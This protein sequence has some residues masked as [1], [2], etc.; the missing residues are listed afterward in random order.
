MTGIRFYKAATN[1]GTHVGSLWSA[2]RPC[3]PRRPSPTKAPPAGSRSASQ[4]GRDQRQHHLRGG[5][6][7]AERALLRH[8][9]SGLTS[10][11]SNPPLTALSNASQRQRRVRVR[12]APAPSRRAPTK[13]ATTTSTS[14]SLPTPVPGP[15]TN[16]TRDRRARSGDGLLE[17]AE[18]RRFGRRIQ[19]HPLHRQR[20]A[21][22]AHASRSR[23]RRQSDVHRAAQRH[24][25]HVPGAG[26]RT[27]AGRARCRRPRT[28]SRRRH[29]PSPSA[30]LSV[31]ASAATGQARVSWSEPV[32]NGGSPITGYVVTPYLGTASSPTPV[33]APADHG[34]RR[35]GS[36][37]R[38]EPTRSR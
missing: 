29:R 10:A 2:R 7:R 36:H 11:V 30:P 6:L 21:D 32:S 1:T 25:L 5:L 13:P 33:Q 19:D 3:W 15:V 23:R 34:D 9:A 22:G 16:V 14:T 35:E 38:Y 31:S 12:P 20:S 17:R 18:R 37:Q 4:T 27:A 24:Q 8:G 28:R 26:V